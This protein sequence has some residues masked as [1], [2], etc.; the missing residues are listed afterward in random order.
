MADLHSPAE[1]LTVH[2]PSELIAELKSLARD[3][4]ISV[5]E[6]VREACLAYSEPRLWEKSYQEWLRQHPD[7]PRAEFG[8]D[9]DDLT[10]SNAAENP[11]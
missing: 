1:A 9:G 6:L 8:I 7:R 2:L 4:Q 3:K 10:A 5:D 11:A